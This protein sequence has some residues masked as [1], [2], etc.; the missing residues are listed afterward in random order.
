[1]LDERGDRTQ[2]GYFLVLL[3]VNQ[4]AGRI[5]VEVPG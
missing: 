1:M 5:E 2:V 3:T 4:V